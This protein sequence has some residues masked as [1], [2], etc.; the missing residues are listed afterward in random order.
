[1][2]VGDFGERGDACGIDDILVYYIGDYTN[3]SH[4]S[5]GKHLEFSSQFSV[6]SALFEFKLI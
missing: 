3:G 2:C 4:G 5:Y 1:M 6:L